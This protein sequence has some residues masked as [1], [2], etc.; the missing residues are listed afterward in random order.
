MKTE[1]IGW[2]SSIILVVTL[3]KQ[4]HKQYRNRRAAA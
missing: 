1:M 4:V 3:L 2:A